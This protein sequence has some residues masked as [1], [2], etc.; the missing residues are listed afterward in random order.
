MQ[1]MM[2]ARPLKIIFAPKKVLRGSVLTASQFSHPPNLLSITAHA[3]RRRSM[4]KNA[5]AASTASIAK[6]MYL[7]TQKL[8]E[9]FYCQRR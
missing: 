6:T 8:E 3:I 5:T 9:S 1:S 7:I 4:I 2:D